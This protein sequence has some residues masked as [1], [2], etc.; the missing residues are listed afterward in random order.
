LSPDTITI[1]LILLLGPIIFIIG[2]YQPFGTL[3]T[4][5]LLLPF[6]DFSI[7]VLNAF[8]DIPIETV[9]ALSRWWFVVILALICVWA[10]RWIHL[11]REE[12]I[13][14]NPSLIDAF[15]VVIVI[16]GLVEALLSP[17]PIAGIT[18]L[19]GYLQ[20]LLVFILARSFIPENDRHLRVL[21]VLLLAVGTVLI[22]MA[23]WQLLAWTEETYKLWGYVDQAGRITGLFRDLE[24]LGLGTGFIR[25][26]STVSGPNELAVLMSI[27]FFLALQ[28]A[29]F[30]PR[31]WR[32]YLIVGCVGFL[33]GLII[34]NSRSAFLGFMTSVGI[35]I[36]YLFYTYRS[37]LRTLSIKKWIIIVFTL[38]LSTAAI[39][40]FMDFMGM[41]DIVIWSIQHPLA[42]AHI[43]ESLLALRDILLHPAGVGMGM[44]WPKGAAILR[45][46]EASYHIEGS[47]FQIAFE[48][49]I[50]GFVVWMIFIGLSMGRNLKL[51]KEGRGS[52]SRIHGGTTFVGWAGS[53]IVFIFLPLM[54]SISLMVLLWFLLGLGVGLERNPLL[55]QDPAEPRLSAAAS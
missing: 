47:L 23:L 42:D 25:P 8:T 7:R 14:P 28:W 46:V 45:G 21:Q 9:N 5:V 1:L 6:R 3:S 50:W 17:N 48:W 30:G 33:V 34:T 49:G 4:F 41:L 31:K 10:V 15:L 22:A 44:V 37:R 18:S 27:L 26:P 24:E 54:Q 55:P 51:W 40:L 29:L 32:P 2:W 20:P 36:L 16:L 35:I 11:Y 39:L 38:L 52:G 43:S 13:R 19:R 12:K 53:L